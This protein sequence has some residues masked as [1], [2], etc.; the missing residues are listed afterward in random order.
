MAAKGPS[1]GTIALFG[2]SFDPPHLGHVLC[3]AWVRARHGVDAIWVLPVARHPFAKPVPPWE[4]RWHL[5]EAA[6]GDLPFVELR[7]EQRRL[8]S[9]Y[10]SDLV[11]ELGRT[12]PDLRFRLIVG[13]DI[14]DELPRW[15][16]GEEL[17]RLAEPLVVPRGGFDHDPLA[18]PAISSTA[19]RERCARREDVRNLVPRKV[20]HL[21]AENGWYGPGDPR[22]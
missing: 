12:H 14:V 15:H 1:P 17:A 21:I 8:E 20:L 3:C 7:D 18:L 13:S 19:I 4:R 11:E 6:F 10:T 16:R 2:G 22:N 9:P 5:C